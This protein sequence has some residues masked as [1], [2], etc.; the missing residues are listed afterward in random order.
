MKL[1]VYIVLT[2]GVY[3]VVS[4]SLSVVSSVEL[5]K[6]CVVSYR[7]AVVLNSV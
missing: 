6:S 5:F 7:M 3:V 1:S 4:V 2:C